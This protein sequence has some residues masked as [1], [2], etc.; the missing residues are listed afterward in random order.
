MFGNKFLCLKQ[1]V[2]LL[3][4]NGVIKTKEKHYGHRERL[5]EK[6][7]HSGAAGL[8]DYEL[9]ELLLTYAVPRRDVKR[10]AKEL[11][12]RFGS[13]RG[14]MTAGRAELVEISGVGRNSAV[15]LNVVLMLMLRCVREKC[16]TSGNVIPVDKSAL[17]KFLHESATE[18]PAD[19]VFMLFLDRRCRL[20]G[21]WHGGNMPQKLH[22][23][24]LISLHA[25]SETLIIARNVPENGAAQTQDEL[26]A[27]FQMRTVAAAF[28]IEVQEYQI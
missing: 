14:V 8:A 28:G 27:A 16:R 22:L 9:L 13:L 25:E 23:L 17:Q 11:L 24:R 3:A 15:L 1:W 12:S 18:H 4:G 6:F 5:K 19:K 20:L 2:F 21:V 7:I 26:D 10:T